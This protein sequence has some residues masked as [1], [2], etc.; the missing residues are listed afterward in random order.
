[1]LSRLSWLFAVLVLSARLPA[2]DV[3]VVAILANSDDPD[4]MRVARHYAVA[5]SLPLESI[6]ALPLPL[7]EQI[8]WSEFVLTLHRPLQAE[9]VRRGWI[10]AITMDLEDAVGRRKLAVSHVRLDALVVC[11]GVPLKI[12]RDNEL[13]EK[14]ATPKVLP[15]N[16]QTNEASVDAELTLLAIGDL[17][18]NGFVPNP[19]FASTDPDAA[20][21]AFIIPVGRLDGPT[22]DDA[23]ALVDNAIKAERTGLIGRAYIDIGGPFAQGDGWLRETADELTKLGFAPDID[24]DKSTLSVTARFDQ[25]VFYFGWYDGAI[26]GPMKDPDFRFP[27]GAIAMHIHSFSATTLRNGNGPWVPSL[28]A[29]GV[30]LTC[31]N[32]N[33]PYLQFTHQP[34]RLVRSL[35]AGRPAGVAALESLSVLGWQAVLIGDPLYQPFKVSFEQQ[36][37]QLVSLPA[38]QVPYVY[39]RKINLLDAKEHSTQAQSQ[40][41]AALRKSASMAIVLDLAKRQLATKDKRGARQTLAIIG[42]L[43]NWRPKDFGMIAAGARLLVEADD[44]A[45]AVKWYRRLLEDR[46]LSQ[47]AR[48]SLL[49]EAQQAARSAMDF[50]QSGRW[51]SELAL[52]SGKS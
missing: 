43:S 11:R 25:P 15:G 6:I 4:S 22:A 24:T 38:F 47:P 17:P 9:L 2:G 41:W 5:R 14:T 10:D 28:V 44:A 19:L 32:V 7:T 1:M 37:A 36:W 49:P 23:M 3:P 42:S 50:T 21:K 20:A 34:Q 39:L 35:A 29:R 18:I 26:S 27:V 8:T 45:G 12:A 30:T 13:A 33:E 52:L 51:E 48:I 40:A 16:L 46:K 31:G